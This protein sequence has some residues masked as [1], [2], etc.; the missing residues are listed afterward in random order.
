MKTIIAK[1]A[2]SISTITVIFLA[3]PVYAQLQ[4][5]P[6]QPPIYQPVTGITSVTQLGLRFTQVIAWFASVVV[7]ISI[8]M[9]LYAG[10]KFM[11]AGGDEEAVGQ[12]RKSLTWGIVG[13]VV[14]GFAYVLPIIVQNFLSG[15]A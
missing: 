10:F 14:A 1:I 7:A 13:L 2:A 9:I 3:F 8:I 12:A 5:A 11:V 6:V 4:Q 15:G